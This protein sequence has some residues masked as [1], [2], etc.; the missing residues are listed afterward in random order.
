MTK[1]WIDHVE[2]DR[3]LVASSCGVGL[4]EVV[5]WR[6]EDLGSFV[7]VW[8]EGAPWCD[9]SSMDIKITVWCELIVEKN[10]DCII[11]NSWKTKRQM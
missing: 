1:G 3:L 4:S 2:I 5:D 9:F 8:R 10:Y 7:V 6:F 11:A